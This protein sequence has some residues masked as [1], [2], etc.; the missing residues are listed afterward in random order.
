LKL[1]SEKYFNP[2]EIPGKNKKVFKNHKNGYNT[3]NPLCPNI[4]L[5]KIL[6]MDLMKKLF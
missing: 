6:N 4:N 3:I 5:L 1:I 2:L